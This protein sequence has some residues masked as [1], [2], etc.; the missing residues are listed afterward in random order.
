MKLLFAPVLFLSLLACKKD[1]DEVKPEKL[2]VGTWVAS[3]TRYITT[4]AG[5][6]LLD[7][8]R[9]ETAPMSYVFS[10]GGAVRYRLHTG[11]AAAVGRWAMNDGKLSLAISYDTTGA[12][13][14]PPLAP[15][16]V[17][18]LTQQRL[19]IRKTHHATSPAGVTTE[20]H[21]AYARR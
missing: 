20:W 5:A 17:M 14:L 9:T 8:T 12:A 6:V 19:L 11:R 18:E 10:D 4:R 3:T 1:S 2:I 7:N 21:Y 15:A 16:D 13:P